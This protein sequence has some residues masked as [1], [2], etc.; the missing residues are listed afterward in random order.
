VSACP[1]VTGPL[2]A[3]DGESC[4]C[5]LPAEHVFSLSDHWHKCTCGAIWVDNQQVDEAR[6]CRAEGRP[7]LE[8]AR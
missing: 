6:R 8:L 5:T 7:F 4:A 3:L 2:W 1:E